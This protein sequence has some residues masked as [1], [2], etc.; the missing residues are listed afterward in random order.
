MG[1]DPHGAG[2]CAAALLAHWD[3][4]WR[5]RWFAVWQ[6][7]GVLREMLQRIS[8]DVLCQDPFRLVPIKSGLTDAL[9]FCFARGSGQIG[10]FIVFGPLFSWYQ[11]RTQPKERASS[12]SIWALSLFSTHCQMAI[13]ICSG[14]GVREVVSGDGERC[15]C[16]RM[17]MQP[18]MSGP[19]ASA[20]S[21]SR[22][23][24]TKKRP[25]RPR[26]RVKSR[27]WSANGGKHAV[28]GVCQAL[29][30]LL[31]HSDGV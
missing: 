13:S 16:A 1:R 8:N 31:G 4:R 22:R 5:D 20:L 27:S 21:S 14:A 15:S 6:L 19:S 7:E 10:T 11:I 2:V 30:M 23:W 18:R 24:R 25:W 26:W 12:A 28:L 9:H 17:Q 29:N 3:C